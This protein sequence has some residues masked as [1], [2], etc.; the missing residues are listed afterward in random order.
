MD[1]DDDDDDECSWIIP[2]NRFVDF[3]SFRSSRPKN[4]LY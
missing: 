1:D 2:V 3:N 4:V